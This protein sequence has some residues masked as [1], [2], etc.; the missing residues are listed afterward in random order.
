MIRRAIAGLVLAWV[1]AASGPAW[2]HG[3]LMKLRSEDSALV[4]ELYYSGGT[5]A[6]GEWI[7]VTDLDGSA[8]PVVF[9]TG[10]EGEFRQAA[11]PGHRYSVKAMGEEG[12]E[13]IMTITVGDAAR[14]TMQDEATDSEESTDTL[15]A[16]ALVGG[17]M[18][19]SVLPALW[20]RRRDRLAGR[21]EA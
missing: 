5:R 4:G 2:A 16:W 19:M 15:P 20:F 9:Q 11:T 14:G 10:A 8:A 1:L 18:L 21:D 13:I 17:L 6:G 12:H 3:L 7:E